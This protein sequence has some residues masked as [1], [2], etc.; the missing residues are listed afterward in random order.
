MLLAALFITG[1][2][3]VHAQPKAEQ[4]PVTMQELPAAVP[5][6]ADI[7]PL[8]SALPGR[9]AQLENNLKAVLDLSITEK[10]YS[11]F[12]ERVEGFAAQLEEIKRAETVNSIRLV[13]LRRLLKDEKTFFEFVDRPLKREIHRVGAW[14]T[15]W[16]EEKNRWGDWETSMLGDREPIQLKSAFARAQTTIDSAM[17]MVLKQLETMLRIQ[18]KG[19]EVKARI[20]ILDAEAQALISAAMRDSLLTA[21]PPMFSRDYFSQFRGELWDSS[22]EKLGELSWPDRGFLALYGWIFIAQ[23]FL[24]LV[25]IFTILR[26]RAALNESEHWKFLADRP[27][28]AGIFITILTQLFFPKSLE[29]PSTLLL[30]YRIGGGVAFARLLGILQ[31]QPWKRQ[32]AYSVIF[33]FIAS[34]IMKTVSFPLPLYRLYTLLVSLLALYFFLRW[35]WESIRDNDRAIYAWLLRVGIL[36]PGVIV[37]AQL[38]GKDGMAAYLFES[39]LTSLTIILAIV[40]FIYMI[41]GGLHWIFFASPV[42]KIKQLRSEAESLARRFGF[43]AETATVVFVMLP[44]ILTTWGAYTNVPQALKSLLAFGFDVGSARISVGLVITTAGTL[45][46]SFL[47]SWILPK[48]LLSEMVAGD[49]MERGVRISV[50]RLI[51]YF[52]IFIGFIVALITLGLDFTKLTIIVSALGVGIGFGLQGIVNNFVCGLILLFERPL[53]VGDTIELG[54]NWANIKEIGLRA[55]TVQTLEQ[56]DVIIPNADLVNNQLTNWTL[57]NRQGRIKL[58][59]G[60]AYGSDVPRVIETLLACAAEHAMVVKSPPP[61]VL[62]LNFGESSLGFELRA[63]VKDVDF[64][65]QVTSE[66]HQAID[67][68]FRE[69]NIEIAFPQRDLH[70]R[71]INKSITVPSMQTT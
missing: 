50:G 26:K 23:F 61:Q 20:D 52:I 65:L 13:N 15:E 67:G 43:L 66:L 10:K 68:R 70:L 8:A 60:V 28:S 3:P 34:S 18:A 27:F 62:F 54:G 11:Q 12:Q 33:L 45:Y 24:F 59:V 17:N 71:S 63:W 22:F 49:G 46:G 42:W 9:L 40:L 1:I 39:S 56:A 6:L 5:G 55:T 31:Q 37:I 41:R 25:V 69:A 2:E 38:W 35:A 14:K 32:A 64:R 57:S 16:L 29:F 51:Q 7:I 36:L 4:P 48:V 30:V 19:G 44:I 58:P 53:R 21:A 47:L